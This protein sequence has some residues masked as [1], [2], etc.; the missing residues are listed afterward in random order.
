[1]LYSPYIQEYI[2][3]RIDIKD[4]YLINF[5]FA[6]REKVYHNSY[7]CPGTDRRTGCSAAP[8]PASARVA[9]SRTWYTRQMLALARHGG[10]AARRRLLRRPLGTALPGRWCQGRPANRLGGSGP[11]LWPAPSTLTF[12]LVGGSSQ[13]GPPARVGGHCGN[14]DLGECFVIRSVAFLRLQRKAVATAVLYRASPRDA[15][16]KYI[17]KSNV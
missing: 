15:Q 7:S 16:E 8:S 6:H 11:P 4:I 12:S 9:R 3:M 2:H 1:M 14:C 10:N 13:S 5:P 17:D